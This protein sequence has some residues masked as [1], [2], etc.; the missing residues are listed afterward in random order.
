MTES[1]D[2]GSPPDFKAEQRRSVALFVATFGC[3]FAVYGF[4]WTGENPFIEPESAVAAGKFAG[5]LMAI[6]LAH[7]MAHYWVARRHG[8]ALS[9]PYFIPFPAAFGTFGAVIRLRSLPPSRTAL[10]E[11]AAAGP[12]AGF[13]VSIAAIAMGLPGTVEHAAP[14]LTWDPAILEALRAPVPEPSAMDAVLTRVSEWTG[15]SVGATEIPLMI[16]AN[17]LVMDLLGGWMLDAPPSRYATLDPLATA[18]W[19]GCL[20]T[21]INLV[22]IGQLDGGH[23]VNAM[24]PRWAGGTSRVLLGA[25]V[26]AGV[27]WTGWAFWAVLLVVMGAWVSLPVPAEPPPSSRARWIAGATAITFG[28]SFMPAPIV[29]EG[30]QLDQLAW[31]NADGEAVAAEVIDELRAAMAD[32]LDRQPAGR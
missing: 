8:F 7:E 10:L 24:A 2:P 6:L 19:V 5:A 17:P 27:L 26:V 28:L 16:L 13:V 11:M 1:I 31:V 30:F 12:I 25:A 20:L 29:I 14:E 15:A 9:L 4:Q 3:V 22:P 32:R 23:I 21:A 18:G